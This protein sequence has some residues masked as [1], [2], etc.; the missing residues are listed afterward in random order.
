MPR[1]TSSSIYLNSSRYFLWYKIP[2]RL[3]HWMLVS[4]KGTNS[5]NKE[6]MKTLSLISTSFFIFPILIDYSKK[7]EQKRTKEGKNK[8]IK[9]DNKTI[10]DFIYMSCFVFLRVHGLFVVAAN[11]KWKIHHWLSI[12]LI[13]M[14]SRMNFLIRIS[15]FFTRLISNFISYSWND[16]ASFDSLPFSQRMSVG[17]SEVILLL[18]YDLNI[19]L[20]QIEFANV[21][22]KEKCKKICFKTMNV[23]NSMENQP[24]TR[25]SWSNTVH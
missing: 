21:H 9:E 17:F 23:H 3:L 25:P 15:N 13:F 14:Q 10:F 4:I 22:R 12:S 6:T 20:F 5:V 18:S 2:V 1:N 7:K 11:W 24:A 16:V 19:I 8:R